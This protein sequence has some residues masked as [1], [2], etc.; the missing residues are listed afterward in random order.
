MRLGLSGGEAAM[1]AIRFAAPWGALVVVALLCGPGVAEAQRLPQRPLTVPKVE[2]GDDKFIV[3]FKPGTQER[4]QPAAR[5]AAIEQLGR[6]NG[7]R[8]AWV[9]RMSG[10]SDVIRA[11]RRL[12]RKA[13]D[14]FVRRLRRDPRIEAVQVDHRSYPMEADPEYPYQWA[15]ENSIVNVDTG[16]IR[17]TQAWYSGFTGIGTVVA[18]LDTG[19]REHPELQG[20]L[21]AGYDFVSDVAYSRD[22]DGR[23]ADAHDPGDAVVAGECGEGRP[24]HAATWH[25]TKVAG[26]IA[27]NYNNGI[28]G[29]GVAIEAQILPVRV[30][31]KCGADDD[32]LADAIRWAAGAYVAGVPPTPTPADVINLSLGGTHWCGYAVQEAINAAVARGV[33]VVVAAGNEAMDAAWSSPANCENVIVV[34]A[35]TQLGTRAGYSNFGAKVDLVAPGGDWGF[36]SNAW[37]GLKEGVFVVSNTGFN[38]PGSPTYVQAT[39]TSLSAPHV[40][41]AVAMMQGRHAKPPAVVERILKATTHD[42]IGLHTCARGC[43]AGL[44]QAATAAFYA[45]VP[46]VYLAPTVV[47][48]GNGT[49]VLKLAYRMSEPVPFPVSFDVYT[50]D[51]AEWIALPRA[52]AGIDYVALPPTRVT[53]PANATG[54]TVDVTILGDSLVEKDEYFYVQTR[55]VAGYGM[56]DE[57]VPVRI[58]E[59]DG[60]LISVSDAEAAPGQDLVFEVAFSTTLEAGRN[61]HATLPAGSAADYLPDGTAGWRQELIDLGERKSFVVVP[62]LPDSGASGSL[63]LVLQGASPY[64]E[65]LPARDI[66]GI[67]TILDGTPL[68]ISVDDVSVL[69]GNEGTRKAVFTVLLSRPAKEAVFWTVHTRDRTALAGEDYTA[70]AQI[71]GTIPAGELAGTFEVTLLG[72]DKDELAEDFEVEI[73][74]AA[75]YSGGQIAVARDIGTGYI[76]NDDQPLVTVADAQVVEGNSGTTQLV[77]TVALSEPSLSEVSFTV[78]PVGETATTANMDFVGSSFAVSVPAQH[79]TYTFAIPVFGDAAIEPNET[80]RVELS[81]PMH[82]AL[83]DPLAIGTIVNDDGA[84]LSISDVAIAEGNATKSMTFTVSLAKVSP[85]PVTYSLATADDSAIAGIDYAALILS[86]QTIPAGQLARA[87]AVTLHGDTQV[88]ENETFVVTLSDATGTNIL[89]GQGVGT[90]LNDDGPTISIGDAVLTEGNAGTQAMTFT[91]SLS[92]ASSAPVTF[93]LATVNATATAGSDYT[94]LVAGSQK[95]PAGQLSKAFNVTINGDTTVEPNE[96]FKVNLGNV[97]GATV[98]DGQATGTIVNDDGATLSIADVGFL[99]GDAGTKTVAFRVSLS[100]ASTV[101]VSFDF[102]TGNGTALNGSDYFGRTVTGQV[103]PAGQLSRLVNV[104]V[105]GDT[106]VEPNEVFFGNLTAGSVSILDGQ[107]MATAVNDDGPTLSISDAQVTEGHSGTKLMT[108]TVQLSQSP[109]APVTYTIATQNGTA[110][111]GSDYVQKSLNDSIP[112][113]MLSKTFSVTINGDTSVE[114]SETVRVFLGGASVSVVDGQGIGTITNDD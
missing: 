92:K 12:D 96:T 34:G 47:A 36:N 75:T 43:G 78:T 7:L 4:R 90:L 60:P 71:L 99:E 2:T 63:E 91:V 109:T 41:A 82:A 51:G 58:A 101:P 85:V 10:D 48:E 45:E 8:L 113:G 3:R 64:G 66:V 26:V 57:N 62:V 80:L 33:P 27:A 13:A 50:D 93:N 53:I 76:L 11:H 111:A 79:T 30:V 22:G 65:I 68:S 81:S 9:R 67:G 70:P 100:Q 37:Y 42:H 54:T 95:I 24:W 31:G 102:A 87:H 74:S 21:L 86:G 32:D 40:A 49:H 97:A 20:K 110:A 15:L 77:F 84:V 35:S 103:I 44:L 25:G 112:A 61:W 23:D 73:V 29:T 14:A 107:A 52:T 69:E 98:F 108:F 39:G 88:E 16:G 17:P 19:Y 28:G 55:N 46:F 114:A 59:D 1:P 94:A 105:G 106:V 72:D 5:A 18:V 56:P 89:D 6:A 38:A 104:S 83:L